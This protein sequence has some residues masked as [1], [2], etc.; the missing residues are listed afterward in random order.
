M[1]REKDLAVLAAALDNACGRQP[2]SDTVIRGI[3]EDTRHLS[4]G[5]LFVAIPGTHRDGASYAEAAVGLGAAAVVCEHELDLE[6]PVL[7]V[8][9]ARLALAQLAAAFYDH[10][11]RSLFCIGVTGTNGKTTICHWIAHLLGAESCALVG[12]VAN[13]SHGLRGLTTPPGSILHRIARDA[14]DEG[15]QTLVIEASSIGL[16]QERLHGIAFDIAA[17]SNLAS[18]HLDWHPSPASYLEAKLRLFRQVKADGSAVVNADDPAAEA[19]ASAASGRVVRVGLRGSRDLRAKNWRFGPQGTHARFH[20]N[21]EEASVCIPAP[22]AHNVENALVA[23][24]TAL[25]AGRSLEA[26]SERLA[27]ASP[28]S[29]RWEVY[30][31]DPDGL[32]A[33]VDFAHNAAGLR[34]M[35]A[36]LRDAAENLVVVFGCPGGTDTDKRKAMGETAGSLANLTIVTSDNPKNE[37]FAA[38]ASDIASGLRSVNAA[39]RAVA[40]RATAIEEAVRAAKAG[41]V[42]LIAGKGHETY[43]I[44]RGEYRP[45]EDGRILEALGFSRE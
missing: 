19:V 3:T 44:V 36:E 32:L 43:Q 24:G 38:I 28:V 8:S 9:D 23:V 45:H 40:D 1:I 27:T 13:E 22:G 25:C 7:R 35:L 11:T 2:E 18:D 15:K 17:F 34:R 14:V 39:Y 26:L 30:R 6:V 42:I 20:W 4:P 29:G 10:P 5:D 41:D 31:R 16:A 37:E 12:T 33:V 21:G